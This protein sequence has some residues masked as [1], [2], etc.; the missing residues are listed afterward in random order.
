MPKLLPWMKARARRRGGGSGGGQPGGGGSGGGPADPF[1][2]NVVLLAGF[3]GADEATEYTAETGQVLTFN[4]ASPSHLDTARVKFGDTSFRSGNASNIATFPANATWDLAAGDSDPYTI[5]W[6]LNLENLTDTVGMFHTGWSTNG[7]FC[8]FDTISFEFYWIDQGSG[9]RSRIKD[10]T[11]IL[12]AD[13]WQH[14][15]IEKNASN[16]LRFYVDGAMID[17]VTLGAGTGGMLTSSSTLKIGPY[18]AGATLH[19]MDEC[20]ITKGVARYDSDSGY[21]VP[22]KAFPRR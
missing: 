10:A 13:T 20:R 8:R 17:S 1:F 5:E 11:G 15:V 4:G 9:S 16:K 18:G 12:A 7:F 19:W 2:S 22:N 14:I 6:W 3:E 21:T